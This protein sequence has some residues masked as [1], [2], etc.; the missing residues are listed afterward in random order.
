MSKP[1]ESD[2]GAKVWP[3]GVAE[4]P[5]FDWPGTVV[6]VIDGRV[7]VD[8]GQPSNP[9]YWA[10][11]E[12]TTDRVASIREWF[13]LARPSDMAS[14]W[15]KV[16][17][18]VAFLLERIDVATEEHAR[19]CDREAWEWEQN[20]QAATARADALQERLD[21]MAKAAVEI[22]TRYSLGESG[23]SDD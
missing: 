10:D 22:Y 4:I 8:H 15:L 17:S 21:D 2:V 5:E 7:K 9:A 13:A 18:D 14:Q 1:K 19:S 6:S 23:A 3:S 16:V 12:L 11:E 20:E